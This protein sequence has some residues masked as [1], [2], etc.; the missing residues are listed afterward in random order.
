M[1]E[2]FLLSKN[3]KNDLLK[4]Y[5]PKEFCCFLFS[6]PKFKNEFYSSFITGLLTPITWQMSPMEQE[7]LPY[8]ST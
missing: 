6:N 5:T 1:F 8:W 3:F 2:C 7:L 4:H